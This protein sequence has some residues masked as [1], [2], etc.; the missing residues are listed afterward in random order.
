MPYAEPMGRDFFK[1]AQ[2]E[3]QG[4]IDR[5]HAMQSYRN[6][7]EELLADGITKLIS[8]GLGLDGITGMRE[9]GEERIANEGD[10]ATLL[11]RSATQTEHG[12]PLAY[13]GGGGSH[14]YHECVA[15][16]NVGFEEPNAGDRPGGADASYRTS[17]L[18]QAK[19]PTPAP[20]PPP[21]P[22]PTP[23]GPIRLT[24]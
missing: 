24:E 11:D 21:A 4:A 16:F 17:S 2:N 3:Y 18:P 14:D 6:P 19:T 13:I 7:A 22:T 9:R 12:N 20:T 10:F 15:R 1:D 23:S 5:K 8:S